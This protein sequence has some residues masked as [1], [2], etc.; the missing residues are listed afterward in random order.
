MTAHTDAY[1]NAQFF[2]AGAPE[3]VPFSKHD[4][5]SLPDHQRPKARRFTVR[6]WDPTT[7]HLTID[8]AVHG[9][10]GYAGPWALRAQ[11]GDRL[12]F[13]G[14]GGGYRPNPD[15]AWYLMAGDE[16]AIPAIA[17]SLEVLSEGD[18]C[19]VLIVVDDA[20]HEIPLESAADVRLEWLHRNTAADPERL[21]VDAVGDLEWSAGP[22]DVFLHG[23]AG[24]VRAV[25]SHL[26]A[27]RGIDPKQAS[28]SPYWRRGAD[29]EAWRAIKKQ[30]LRDQERDTRPT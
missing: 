12:Q 7:R 1:V 24:E 26:V 29:D 14:P 10:R 22:V 5:D 13:T 8:F 28:I 18:T 2:P 19:V 11:P 27:E 23:E 6:A 25:R 17:A 9:D 4:L 15:A 16:S 3:L 21:L 30:W 20:D